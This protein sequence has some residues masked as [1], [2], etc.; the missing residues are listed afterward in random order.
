MLAAEID[1]AAIDLAQRHALELRMPQRL[2]Q[3]S[4]VAAADDER[5]PRPPMGEQRHMRHH[6]VIDE[7]VLR[8][9]LHD[10]VEHHHPP[11]FERFEDDQVLM[12]GLAIEEDAVRLQ[13]AAETAV[14][15]LFDPP[16]HRCISLPRMC[17]LTTTL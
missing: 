2:A 8:R 10:A 11:E 4:A 5:V 1:H 14:Q 15:R 3:D 9:Q 12:L 13:A 7:L 17:S 6:L 16:F